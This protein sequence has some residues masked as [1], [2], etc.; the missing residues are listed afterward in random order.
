MTTGFTDLISADYNSIYLHNIKNPMVPSIFVARVNDIIY[1]GFDQ[2]LLTFED[3]LD[4]TFPNVIVPLAGYINFLT[5][6]EV[7]DDFKIYGNLSEYVKGTN[8]NEPLYVKSHEGQLQQYPFDKIWEFHDEDDVFKIVTII[9]NEINKRAL[10]ADG[11]SNCAEYCLNEVLDNVLQHSGVESGYFMAQYLKGPNTINFSIFDYG[12]GIYNTLNESNSY[13]PIGA[14]DAITMSVKENVTRD[15]NEHQGNG[16]FMLHNLVHN[17]KSRLS[18]CTHDAHYF[19]EDNQIKKGKWWLT[20][21]RNNERNTKNGCTNVSFSLDLN[22]AVSVK[23]SLGHEKIDIRLEMLEDDLTG[24]INYVVSERSNTGFGTRR[25]GKRVRLDIINIINET[26]KTV[27]IDFEGVGIISSS[28]ADESIG[29]LVKELGFMRFQKI[30]QLK[31]ANET[32][33]DIINT[34]VMKRLG[35]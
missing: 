33:T 13:F 32:I 4:F 21:N 15:K 17:N 28:F 34:A 12:L 9:I 20:N 1:R 35:E 29:K 5:N 16:L 19:Y 25:S 11:I 2:V 7:I 24:L 31:N 27:N 26:K 30:V 3:N 22:N 18:I 6:T 10:L 14:I 23:D 8:F